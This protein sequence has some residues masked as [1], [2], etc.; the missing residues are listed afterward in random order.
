MVVRRGRRV[1]LGGGIPG[2]V[3]TPKRV[4]TS[5]A[6]NAQGHTSQTSGTGTQ[7]R[8]WD[9]R[10][11]EHGNDYPSYISNSPRSLVQ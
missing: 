1:R 5:E 3:L 9:E 6:M 10:D 2:I 7:G 11:I 4:L 8:D